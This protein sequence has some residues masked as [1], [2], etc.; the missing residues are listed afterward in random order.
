MDLVKGL[1]NAK[2]LP[3]TQDFSND[4]NAL[5]IAG[6]PADTTD[7]DLYKIFGSFGAIP[8]RGVRA[9]LGDD[10]MCKGFGF[11]N[12]VEAGA[13]E[14]AMMTLN[15]TTLPNGKTLTVQPKGSKK[16]K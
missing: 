10:G 13:M 1:C 7:L 6:L 15:G 9:M 2:A 14:A 12:Y 8:P 5:F 11:V 4:E 3:G 16:E